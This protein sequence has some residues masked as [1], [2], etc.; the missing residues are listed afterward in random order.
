MGSCSGPQDAITSGP[1]DNPCRPHAGKSIDVVN[2][3][4]VIHLTS[5]DLSIAERSALA[6]YMNLDR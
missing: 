1:F 3:V 2:C 5:R 4:K 6:D